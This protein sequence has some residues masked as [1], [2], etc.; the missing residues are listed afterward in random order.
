MRRAVVAGAWLTLALGAAGA[1]RGADP[2]TYKVRLEGAAQGEVADTLIASSDLVTLRTAAPV[3]PLGLILRAR[4]DTVRLKVVLESYGYY[5]SAVTATIDGEA[6]VNADLADRLAAL[7]AGKAVSVVVSY[8]PGPLYHI[9]S[10]RFEGDL[11]QSL[12]SQF[13]LRA[14]QAAI[15]ADVLAAGAHLL[16][17][18]QNA[19]FAFAK[20]GT[21]VAY[22][23]PD[24][25]ELDVSFQVDTGRVARIGA[26]RVTGLQH[27]RL[28]AVLARLKLHTG[29]PYSAQ[30]LDRARRSLL[31]MGVFGTVDV[32][33]ATVADSDGS[34]PVTFSVTERKRHAVSLSAAWSTDLGG[35]GGVTWSDRNVFGNGDQLNLSASIINL[36]GSATNGLGY[37]TG[38]RLVVPQFLQAQQTLQISL[39]AIKQSLLAYDQTAETT[40]V[41]L[42]RT[43]SRFWSAS[44]GFTTTQETIHQPQELPFLGRDTFYY[45]LFALPLS[46]RYD[47]TDLVSPLVDPTHGF[48]AA[49]TVSPTL[50]LGPPN[51]TYIITQLRASAYLDLH[52][53]IGSA[54]GRTVVAMRGLSGYAQGARYIDLP[55]D[56]RFYA[57]GSGTI[58]GYRFQSVGQQFA[59][60]TPVGGTAIDAGSVELRQR[61]GRSYGFAVFADGGRVA[62]TAQPFSG[63]YQF[64]AGAGARF[65]TPI[66]PLRVDFALPLERSANA[67]RFE[68]YIGLGQSF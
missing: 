67:D 40:G 12:R 25:R 31:D 63:Q 64:G 46:L 15:A 59:D 45:T 58:R 8:I 41:T 55:P 9:G 10:I 60:G 43:L 56:Q 52:D 53:L 28:P 11:P 32:R 20:V 16:T 33:V 66:G 65:Y 23:R 21:P 29:D 50:S 37:D 48:R 57:G 2:L 35:S 51:A 62:Q 24:A 7:P 26:I 4:G 6:L 17:A 18:L 13:E 49:L 38:A 30:A 22:E 68:V 3:G 1:V 14:G 39:D 34:V 54:P 36:S 44:V 5:Q 27:T 47:S 19:G 42:T 61:V